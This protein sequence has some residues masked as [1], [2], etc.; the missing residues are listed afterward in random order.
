[1]SARKEKRVSVLTDVPLVPVS[2]FKRVGMSFDDAWY[3]VGPTIQRNRD[4]GFERL[5]CIAFI[6]GMRMA[7]Y[8]LDLSRDAS[9]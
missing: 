7:Q 6:E 4:V 8:A 5:L 3:L 2:H 9:K 1:M